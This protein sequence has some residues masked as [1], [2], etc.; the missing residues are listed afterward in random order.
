[1]SGGSRERRLA[2]LS[3]SKGHN[4][5]AGGPVTYDKGADKTTPSDEANE[6]EVPGSLPIHS[7]GIVPVLWHA[8]VAAL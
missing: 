1:M 8:V 2:Q 6:H 3:P 5:G 4:R 7:L